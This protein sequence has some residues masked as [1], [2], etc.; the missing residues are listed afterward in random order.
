MERELVR[1]LLQNRV[2]SLEH[3]TSFQR[4]HA[5]RRPI[6]TQTTPWFQFGGGSTDWAAVVVVAAAAVVADSDQSPRV[7][8]VQ[9]TQRIEVTGACKRDQKQSIAGVDS[10]Q[11]TK[12]IEVTGACKRDQINCRGR[13]RARDKAHLETGAC[14]RDQINC[15]GLQRAR[16]RWKRR[17]QGMKARSRGARSFICLVQFLGSSLASIEGCSGRHSGRCCCRRRR[18]RS[19]SAGHSHGLFARGV[20]GN[21]RA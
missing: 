13:Q 15:R 4:C 18:R 20:A 21:V 16:D 10:V 3:E 1:V 9:E 2:G 5:G 7:D 12:R 14:K 19:S 6:C 11:E 8:S 17:V